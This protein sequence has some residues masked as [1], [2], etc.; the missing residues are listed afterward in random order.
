MA[1]TTIQ[2]PRETRD[3]LAE[4]AEE[5]GLS[6]EQLVEAL[7]AEHPTA[8][9]LAERLAVDRETVRRVIGVGISDEEFDQAPDVR[10]NTYRIAADKVRMTRGTAPDRLD[11][12]AVNHAFPGP[13]RRAGR[14]IGPTSHRR[15]AARRIGTSLWC[16]VAV[17][18]PAASW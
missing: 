4:L 15:S 5:R 7:A 2:V 8:A 14:A 17:P 16:D 12:S 10:G 11:S 9:Q 6:I 18:G 13:A 1:M 3:H